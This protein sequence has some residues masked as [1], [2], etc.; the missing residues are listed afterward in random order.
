MTLLALKPCQNIATSGMGS[1]GSKTLH[2]L[3]WFADTAAPAPLVPHVVWWSPGCTHFIV[4][5]DMAGSKSSITGEDFYGMYDAQVRELD[6]GPWGPGR[7][8]RWWDLGLCSWCVHR[9]AVPMRTVWGH[10]QATTL[11]WA[12]ELCPGPCLA[13]PHWLAHLPALDMLHCRLQEFAIKHAPEL[14]MQAVPSL[15][16]VYTEEAGYVT[17]DEAKQQNLH[18][19]KLSGT[20][21]RQMLRSGEEIPEW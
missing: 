10:C 18:I 5:R 19:K 7:G 15:D 3:P 1:E 20:K 13:S 8:W 9:P 21:F 14:G 16:V 2:G 6:K 11:G 17:A 12:V 4:G